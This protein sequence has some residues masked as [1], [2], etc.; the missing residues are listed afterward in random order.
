M[1][2]VLVGN[3]PSAIHSKLGHIIDSFD[4]V[5]RFNTF[6]QKG[7]EEYVGR[8]TDIWAVNLGYVAYPKRNEIQWNGIGEIPKIV[9]LAPKRA[10]NNPGYGDIA[11]MK[12]PPGVTLCTQESAIEADS[13]YTGKTW[14]STGVLAILEFG[15]CA[16]V[17][18]D[19]FQGLTHHYVKD[20][21]VSRFHNPT[22]EKEFVLA[23]I[24]EGSVTELSGSFDHDDT[25][26][27]AARHAIEIG[28]ATRGLA[29]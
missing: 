25:H 4:I 19:C 22:L 7:F 13:L 2:T 16:I 28:Q 26:G 6:Y 1:K 9:V 20:K 24:A 15:P 27:G 12:L 21:A 11:K 8:K 23:K 5:V 10:G 29:S 17:G 14:A 3:G 18:F